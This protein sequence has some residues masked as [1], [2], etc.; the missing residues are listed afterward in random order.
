MSS[1]HTLTLGL[2]GEGEDIYIYIFCSRDWR[3]GKEETR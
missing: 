3:L 1:S 2:E